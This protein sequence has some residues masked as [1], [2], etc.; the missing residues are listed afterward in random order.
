MYVPA[1]KLKLSSLAPATIIA[2]ALV[3]ICLFV[4]AE[5]RFGAF[6]TDW[7]TSIT[8]LMAGAA[9]ERLRGIH[10]APPLVAADPSVADDLT[11]DESEAVAALEHAQRYEDGY[12]A[13]Q[14]TKPQT[15][16][17]ALVDSPAALCAWVAEKHVSWTDGEGVSGLARDD[18]FDALSTYWFTASGAS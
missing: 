2:G 16:G 1:L 15:I 17:Y 6:G 14:S 12:G 18:L 9:P 11:D 4:V 7:G 13:L 5:E 8:T 10:L 3:A